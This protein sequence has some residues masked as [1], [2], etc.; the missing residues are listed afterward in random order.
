LKT[1]TSLDIH[2]TVLVILEPA[3]EAP[4]PARGYFRVWVSMGESAQTVKA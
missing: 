4:R 3:T 2:D 1:D